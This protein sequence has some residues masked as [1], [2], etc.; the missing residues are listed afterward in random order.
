MRLSLKF[1]RSFAV[2]AFASLVSTGITPA[3]AALI[4]TQTEQQPTYYVA[5][6]PNQTPVANLPSQPV[7]PVQKIPGTS[8]TIA[9]GASIS[10]AVAKLKAGDTLYLKEGTY[11]GSAASFQNSGTSSSYIRV[12]GLGNVVIDA[13]SLPSTPLFNTNGRDYIEFRNLHV[14]KGRIGIMVNTGSNNIVVDNFHSD[15]SQYS[16]RMSGAS[17]VTIKNSTAYNGWN[18]YRGENG[19]HHVYI[20]N[21]QTMYSKDK[22]AG[23][24]PNYLNGD[25]FIFESDN[26]HITIKNTL[27]ANHWDAGFDIKASDSY[28]ENIRSYGNKNGIKAWGKNI[29]IVNA[30]VFG[31]KRQPKPSGGYV[32]GNGLNARSGTIRIVNSTFVDNQDVDIKVGT[33]AASVRLENSIV[34]H[35]ITIGKT[36]ANYG[37]FSQSGTFWGDPKFVSWSTLNF[38]LQAGS[39]AA[40]KGYRY[41]N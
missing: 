2:I 27:S 5:V 20:D 36:L 18:G 28:L 11:K 7:T 31:N 6:S 16:V 24:D 23:Y 17:Y 33:S 1:V 25:G 29:T 10:S 30:L 12:V 26:H 9:P 37:S 8:Y 14:T 3:E 32:D 21:V 4:P 13:S 34:A 35:R 40:G 15:G 19:T 38:R 22:Y 39:P 41:G